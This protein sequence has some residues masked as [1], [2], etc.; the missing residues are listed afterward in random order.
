MSDFL[1]KLGKSAVDVANKAGNKAGELVEVGKLKGKVAS[2]KSEKS[3]TIKEL[4]DRCYDLFKDED[5]VDSTIK[6]L[7]EKITSLGSEIE[8]LEGEIDNVREE[9]KEKRESEYDGDT[10]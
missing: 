4:G 7:C 10:L 9:Y 6:S 1:S 8:T 2:L 5:D 3:N